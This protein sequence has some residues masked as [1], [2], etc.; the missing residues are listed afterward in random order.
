MPE[1]LIYFKEY[2]SLV[3]RRHDLRI[4]VLRFDNGGEYVSALETF[5]KEESIQQHFFF[6]LNKTGCMNERIVAFL[7]WL[8]LLGRGG[9]HSVVRPK[10]S[11]RCHCPQCHIIL[12][13]VWQVTEC[14]IPSDIW[15]CSI[16]RWK[17]WACGRSCMQQAREWSSLAMVTGSASRCK[18]C[19]IQHN[20]DPNSHTQ[21]TSTKPT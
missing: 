17:H 3:I 8:E 15:M 10:S 21:S 16:P 5:C 2:C 6:H 1:V 11:S 18:N 12:S 4:Q 13:L 19:M 14:P 20:E 7:P 9:H